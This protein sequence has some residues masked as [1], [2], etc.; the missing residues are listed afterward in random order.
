M[1][2]FFVSVFPIVLLDSLC[3]SSKQKTTTFYPSLTRTSKVKNDVVTL[4]NDNKRKKEKKK[5]PRTENGVC[6][7]S[8]E[9]NGSL[10]LE[11]YRVEAVYFKRNIN[12]KY[13]N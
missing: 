2:T 3:A 4:D 12:E 9:C 7:L 13:E 11:A 8:Y 10:R 5:P 1:A 6:F